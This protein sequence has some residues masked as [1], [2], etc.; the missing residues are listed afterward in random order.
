M[1]NSNTEKID[2]DFECGNICRV[3]STTEE[4]SEYYL[5]V[6]NDLNT[7]GYNNWFFYRF[8]NVGKGVRRFVIVNL[9]KKTSFFNQGM[10]ISIFSVKKERYFCHKKI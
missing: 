3:Y 6:E 2:S 4:E 10:M 8:R 1:H 5:L 7:Y 9:I